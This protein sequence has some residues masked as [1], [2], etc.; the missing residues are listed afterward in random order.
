M[1]RWWV[2]AVLAGLWPASA[3]AHEFAIYFQPNSTE[4][5]GR[6][7]QVVMETACYARLSNAGG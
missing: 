2:G 6:F 1:K 3:G 4:V 7:R 5:R